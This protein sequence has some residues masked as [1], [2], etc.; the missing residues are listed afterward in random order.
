MSELISHPARPRRST[1]R[2]ETISTVGGETARAYVP[3]PLPPRPPLEIDGGLRARLDAA[4]LA[5][6]RLDSVSTLLPDTHLFLWM[7][8]RKEAVLSSQI[9]GT[10]SSLSD[11]LLF[12][13]NELPGVPVDDVVEVSRYVAALDHG[14]RR[15]REGFPLSNRLIREVHEILLSGGRGAEKNPGEFRRSQN[16]I[17]GS[18]PGNARF[19]PPPPE[20]V[21]ECM[22]QLERWLHDE[23][24]RTPALLKAALSHVQ[25]ETIHPFLDG[26]GRVGR[27][28]V[29]LLL[30][31]EGVLQEPLLYLSLYLKQHRDRYYDL[32]TRVRTAGEWE[33]WVAFFADG[34]LESATGAVNT[35]RRL[36]ALARDD[37]ARIEN[38]AG[39][40]ASTALRLH[41]VLLERPL[42]AAQQLAERTKL[43]MPAVNKGLAVLQGVG[44]VREV[45][46]RKRNRL[47]SYVPYIE[48]LSEGTEPL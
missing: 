33:S 1:G 40:V 18:R 5:L 9:E 34:V 17:G 32:L 28:L 25:F 35:A 13:A 8:V 4:L 26:N 31:V 20:L 24:E 14:L 6:G 12:E 2:W 11:L 39:R 45:T 36:D 42:Q 41:Q 10:Q 48:I 7:Y 44:I 21:P 19:V 15:V 23:P 22:G 29:T 37:R 27:L 43:S 3:E 16:W 46:G 47:F 38:D 30:C